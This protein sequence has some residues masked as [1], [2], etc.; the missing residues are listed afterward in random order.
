MWLGARGL[1]SPSSSPVW[2]S[3]YWA[4]GGR[5]HCR[6]HGSDCDPMLQECVCGERVCVCVC[7]RHRCVHIGRGL[8]AVCVC[9]LEEF[10]SRCGPVSGPESKCAVEMTALWC[11]RVLFQCLIYQ[12]G[13]HHGEVVHGQ[14]C[15]CFSCSVLSL[16]GLGGVWDGGTWYVWIN[17]PMK[18][19][20]CNFL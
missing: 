11:Y 17:Y 20:V 7:I 8:W 19:N 12:W 10:L 9:L 3:T 14:P 5:G 16:W 4:L 6:V 13:Q 1:C 15:P 2:K 18:P